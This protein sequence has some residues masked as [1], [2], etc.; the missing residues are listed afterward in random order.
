MLFEELPAGAAPARGMLHSGSTQLVWIACDDSMRLENRGK[1]GSLEAAPGFGSTS[2]VRTAE[3]DR[4]ETDLKLK[5]SRLFGNVKIEDADNQLVC[6]KM[7]LFGAVPDDGPAVAEAVDREAEVVDFDPDADPFELVQTENSV[8]GKLLIGP[9]LELKRVLC[10]DNVVVSTKE[11]DKQ[12]FAGGDIGEYL[13][14]TRKMVIYSLPP[15]H[16]WL[17]GEGRKQWC[18]RIVYDVAADRIH[19]EGGTF[20]ADEKRK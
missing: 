5:E 15:R 18:Q 2:G 14:S 11:K 19:G 4:S 17:K 10:E 6:D 9:D 16:A 20:T 3:A 12:Y 1:K 8:P 7:T 13:S